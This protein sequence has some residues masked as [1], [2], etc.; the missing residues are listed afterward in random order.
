M[1]GFPEDQYRLLDTNPD[2]V[3]QAARQI[4]EDHFPG[5]RHA[6]ILEAINISDAVS[7]TAPRTTG[8]DVLDAPPQLVAE[9]VDGTQY[10]HPRPAP[11]QALASSALGCNLGEAFRFGRGGS[12]GWWIL[13]QQEVRLGKDVLVPDLAGWRCR[14]VPELPDVY[15]TLWSG[16]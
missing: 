10:T 9:I 16:R 4:L 6:E 11:A 7:D 8:Q 14:R 5:C 12:G 1:V 15:F 2:L 13:P 3:R